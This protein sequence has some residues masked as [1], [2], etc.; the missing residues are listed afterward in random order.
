MSSSVYESLPP[1]RQ[2][3][4]R[5]PSPIIR[6]SAIALPTSP[7]MRADRRRKFAENSLAAGIMAV[8]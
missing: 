6:K 7:R 1:E 4:T 2:T 5:S 8:F 3:I